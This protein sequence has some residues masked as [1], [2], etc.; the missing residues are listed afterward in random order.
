MYYLSQKKF[1][2][3]IFFFIFVSSVVL[4]KTFM[5]L[6]FHG[7]LLVFNFLYYL[8][9]DPHIKAKNMLMIFYVQNCHTQGL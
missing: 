9:L 1:Y 5:R 7:C 4:A 2:D 6:C 8:S 3:E